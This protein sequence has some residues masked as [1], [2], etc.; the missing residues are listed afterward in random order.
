MK[1]FQPTLP[2]RG[3][4]LRR[5]SRGDDGSN[6][7]PRSPHGERRADAS[8][9]SSPFFYFNPRS[10]HGERPKMQPR[11]PASAISTHAPRTGSDGGFVTDD[12][13]TTTF[14]PT[15]P[16]RGATQ[17][18]RQKNS[19]LSFQPTLPARGATNQLLDLRRRPSI[20]THAPRTGSDVVYRREKKQWLIST[21]APR[22][23]S[24]RIPAVGG[25]ETPVIST[26]APRT[27][28][29]QSLS[30]RL[31]RRMSIS[32]HAPR[33]GSDVMRVYFVPLPT[34]FNPRSPHGERPRRPAPR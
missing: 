29:D 19:A 24:D 30:G 11:V 26:H 15:L 9:I 17:P 25:D 7:N 31:N 8:R 14:Q 22:T 16:A 1:R 3:A 34:H 4:T 2:A 21:H 13:G 6:F 32:T 20:S 12:D 28:S 18:H 10:P 33:T 5:R 23:G 27:G